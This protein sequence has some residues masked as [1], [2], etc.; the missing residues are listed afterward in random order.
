MPFPLPD[1]PDTRRSRGTGILTRA[2]SDQ[3]YGIGRRALP[4][5][6]EPARPPEGGRARCGG[7]MAG[8]MWRLE[9]SPAGRVPRRF[10]V[11]AGAHPSPTLMVSNV[12]R[13]MRH[14]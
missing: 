1:G 3:L 11:A 10:P 9:R 2:W 7:R 14:F 6:G 12:G 13:G 4:I 8:P 5:P